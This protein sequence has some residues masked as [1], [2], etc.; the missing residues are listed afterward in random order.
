MADYILYDGQ[1]SGEEIDAFLS[2]VEQTAGT[3]P[4]QAELAG[5]QAKSLPYGQYMTVEKQTE[6]DGSITLVFGVPLG[7]TGEQG[8]QGLPGEQGADGRSAYEA[9][10]AGGYSGTEEE[11]NETL[12]SVN[13]IEA[14]AAQSAQSA[15]GSASAASGSAEN[16]AESADAAAASETNA[17]N[18]AAAAAESEA[19]AETSET[20]AAASALAASGSASA[21]AASETNAGSSAIAAAQSESNAADSASDA[22]AAKEAAE[23]AQA[24][25]ENLGVTSETLAPGSAAAVQKTVDPET[26]AVTL[27]FGLPQGAT[28]ETGAAAGFG[29]P[30]ATID[31]SVGTPEV[32]ITATG[33]DTAK[34]FSFAFRNI[35]G[36][37]GAP[38][39]DGRAFQI[40]DI[41]Q[42]LAE[43]EADFPAGDDGYY[44]VIG[45]NREIYMW[46]PSEGA[47]VSLGA[48]EGPQGPKGDK[49]D[50]G[51]TGPQGEQGPQGV[52]GDAGDTGPQGPQGETGATGEQGP[53]GDPGPKA[54][55]FSLT[56]PAAGWADNA[57]T[58]EDENLIVSGYDYIPG[59]AAASYDAYTDAG[60]HADDLTTDGRITF[61]CIEVPEADLTVN[62]LRI[63]VDEE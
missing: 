46:S 48:L 1:Y 35:K 19:S 33:P 6:A 5:V 13:Q 22:E 61:R 54:K 45:E 18:S 41:Y 26:G 39:A 50:T 62:F 28:G 12:A 27:G 3:G 58:V 20:N 17:A 29:T 34:V 59:P 32:E 37:T 14:N 42:T 47:W 43:L 49:G 53:R 44:Q 57:Q 10:R 30:E 36:E 21:A 2:R 4:L 25:I 8:P 38:G 60:V 52:K 24:A 7:Q 56:L 40:T 31:G 23:A 15:A 11:F 63:E 16:A 9:A 51:A 55:D